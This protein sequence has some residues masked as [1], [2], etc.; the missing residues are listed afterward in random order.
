[1]QG[2]HDAHVQELESEVGVTEQG[3]ATRGALLTTRK[4]W[5]EGERV[6]L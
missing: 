6:R 2:Q 1:M 5:T 3:T 4:N